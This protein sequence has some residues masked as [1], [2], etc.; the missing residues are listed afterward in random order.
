MIIMQMPAL[1]MN[2][3]KMN[4]KKTLYF[5]FIKEPSKYFFHTH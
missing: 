4:V 1:T 2:V 5:K 3:K